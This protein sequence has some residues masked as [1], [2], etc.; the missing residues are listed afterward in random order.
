MIPINALNPHSQLGMKNHRSSHK[1]SGEIVNL[2]AGIEGQSTSPKF[3]VELMTCGLMSVLG[4]FSLFPVIF[5]GISGLIF[6]SL[7]TLSTKHKRNKE[8]AE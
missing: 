2:P 5:A 4:C 3:G 1:P 7:L 6:G 8:P